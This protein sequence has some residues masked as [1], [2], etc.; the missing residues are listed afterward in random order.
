MIDV[1]CD[2]CA[3]KIGEYTGE[4]GPTIPIK[5]RF[6]TR[7]DGTQPKHGSSTAWPCPHCKQQI[8]ELICVMNACVRSMQ[9]DPQ[10][11][12]ELIGRADPET[13]S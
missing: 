9:P 13:R 6:Y 1:T 2:A 8:N 7:V 5:S 4:I 11:L 12:T 3:G 10:V